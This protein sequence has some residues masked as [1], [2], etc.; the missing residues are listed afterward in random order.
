MKV[1]SINIKLGAMNRLRVTKKLGFGA[2]LDGK[3]LDEILLPKRYVPEG[4]E[5]DDW[6][7]VFV[8]LDSEDRPVATTEPPLAMVGELAWLQ[9]VSV[10]NMG[11]FLDWGLPKDLL[12]PFSEQKEGMDRGRFYIVYVYLDTVSD[13]LVGSTKL[14]KHIKAKGHQYAVGDEVE[15]IVGDP[16]ELG[17][18]V[19][20]DKRY[21]GVIYRNEIFQEVASGQRLTGYIKKLRPDG[22]IDVELQ[23]SGTGGRE[24]LAENIM[25]LLKE[26]GGFLPVTDKSPPEEIQE[27]FQVSKRAYKRAVGGLYKQRLISIDEDGIRLVR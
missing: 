10:N 16:F 25:A 22:K 14:H 4:C 5:V 12:V 7:E 1:P 9:V 3:N 24:H 8:Y 6:L 15:L 17:Y 19:I 2:Y 27:L 26:Q 21:L 18:N 11:A 20:I 13:R 23:R